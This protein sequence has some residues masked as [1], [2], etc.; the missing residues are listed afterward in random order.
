MKQVILTLVLIAFY[1]SLLAQNDND[2]T[3]KSGTITY[4]QIVKMEIHLEG[5]ASQFADMLPKE[6]KTKKILYFNSNTSLY[7]NIKE[8][9]SDDISDMHEGG[10][11]IKMEEPDN[12]IFSDFVNKT[13]TEQREFMT[14]LFLIESE[15]NS[16]GWKI[17]ANQK[18]ILGY[19][20]QEAVKEEDDK[21][22]IAWF[23]PELQIVAGPGHINNLPGLV[24]AV[25]I[26]DGKQT[27]I[28]LNIE[29]GPIDDTVLIKPKKGKKVTEE[30][31]KAIV[32][33]KMKEMGV[34][35]EGGSHQ[36]IIKIK[37]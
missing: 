32:D 26:N 18:N 31:F 24:L 21:K 20:C 27:I 16:K 35:G 33:E 12:K 23:A 37:K 2:K 7:E 3:I 13:Q 17:S 15:M 36:I 34:E 6:R 29:E 19:V 10:M 14:R 25:D 1:A 28:A 22:I 11:I 4:E 8:D 30:E 9:D 5:D